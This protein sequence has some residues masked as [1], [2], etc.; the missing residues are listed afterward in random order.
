MH[1]HPE[2]GL[3]LAQSKIEEAR[4]RARHASALRDASLDRQAWGVEAGASR[5]GWAAPTLPTAGRSRA[6]RRSPGAGTPR[7]TKG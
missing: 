4:S 6:R 1:I 5:N 7:T 2:L 3:R